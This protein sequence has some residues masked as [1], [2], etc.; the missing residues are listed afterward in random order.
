MT[1]PEGDFSRWKMDSKTK[2][3]KY[4][5]KRTRTEIGNLRKGLIDESDQGTFVFPC[6]RTGLVQMSKQTEALEVQICS[7]PISNNY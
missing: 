6:L 2:A 5:E 3:L 1:R 7:Q 4:E